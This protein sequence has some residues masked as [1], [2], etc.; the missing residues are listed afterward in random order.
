MA[1]P[2]FDE[3]T[4]KPY[5]FKDL[6]DIDVTY[7]SAHG[8]IESAW[9]YQK[10]DKTFIWNVT[11][12]NGITATL[13]LPESMKRESGDNLGTVGGGSYTIVVGE[14]KAPDTR[15]VLIFADGESGKG[16]LIG[17]G[18]FGIIADPN[19]PDNLC[20]SNSPKSDD[21]TW[22]YLQHPVTYKPGYTY[23][24]ECDVMIASSGT[25]NVTGQNF[26]AEILCNIP[27]AE[28]TGAKKDH[29]VARTGKIAANGQWTHWTFDFTIPEDS[30]ERK[31][32]MFSLYT[33]PV[34]GKGVGYLFDN[35]IVR[36][37]P[38]PDTDSD[39]DA[40]LIF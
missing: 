24:V 22:L 21:E 32:D 9:S 23:S 37:N 16:S 10:N 4:V 5:F 35:L 30:T 3:I 1:K 39:I 17:H 40:D 26:T 27:Y 15:P 28:S 36:E 2:G 34:G 20:Y 11:I 14:N 18:N 13:A 29:V 31:Y 38:L 25:T 33:D 7:K 12:P 19:D 6:K 8:L